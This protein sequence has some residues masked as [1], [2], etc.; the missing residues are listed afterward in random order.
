MT[1]SP[2]TAC[3]GCGVESNED[4][5]GTGM[6]WPCCQ[7]THSGALKVNAADLSRAAPPRWA[8]QD[9]IVRGYLNL[10][11]GN[12]GVGKGTLAAW[13][14]ARLTHGELPGDFRGHPVSVGVL[15]DEDSFDDVWTPR[16]HAAGANL[17][18]LVVQ[19]ERP[20]GGFVN[21]REDRDK[22]AA[23]VRERRIGLLFFDQLLDNLGVG[24]DD[25][26]QKAVRDALQPLRSL[27]REL[28]I[29]VLGCLHPNK[30][31]ESFRQL[32]AGAPAFNSVSRSSLLVAE[33]PDDKDVRVLV[34]GKGNL[35]QTPP[36]IE[37]QIIEHRFTANGFDFKVP[38]AQG[39]HVGDLTVDDLVGNET[40][41]AEHS[42]V[43]DAAEIIEALLPRDG[44]WHLAKP[45]QEACVENG[46]DDRTV[47]RAKNR[48]H[49]EHRRTSAFQAPVEW[50]WPATADTVRTLKNDVRCV[51]SVQ[52]GNGRK[53]LLSGSPDTVDTV[54]SQNECPQCVPTGQ[55]DDPWPEGLDLD[56]EYE[57]AQAKLGSTG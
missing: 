17:D 25:W 38:V 31:G 35:S 37:F 12:E 16:L 23:I 2:I 20:D 8:W 49:I 36:A 7:A 14:I 41:I 44:E 40:K 52:S 13:T 33:H 32:V 47:R 55:T 4:Y 48:L 43:G 3:P 1:D 46:I 9:R 19:I 6:C 30:R 34:R 56:A 5:G 11:L 42:K 50:R 10:L 51:R 29:A 28:D 53:P 27:A 18:G 45:I 24:T 39:F 26:R 54:D 21:I 22:L 57:R 15:G